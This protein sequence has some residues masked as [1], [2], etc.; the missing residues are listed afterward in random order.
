[1]YMKLQRL[2]RV[3]AERVN[4]ANVGS[5]IKGDAIKIDC[6]YDIKSSK[7][8]RRENCSIEYYEDWSY[9]CI[10]NEC[11]PNTTPPFLVVPLVTRFPSIRS[12]SYLPLI[13]LSPKILLSTSRFMSIVSTVRA[14]PSG[15]L[16]VPSLNLK[17]TLLVQGSSL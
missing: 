17:L 13:L 16:V 9:S 12:L 1:M 2:S 4:E 5:I 10:T 15:S 11:I 6:E 7:E 3:Y 14:L 8:H